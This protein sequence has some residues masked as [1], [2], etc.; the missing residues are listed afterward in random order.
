R[1]GKRTVWDLLSPHLWWLER[2]VQAETVFGCTLYV[3]TRE[4]GGRYIYY[5]GIWEPNLTRWI[6][7]RLSPDDTFI[8]VGANI[9]Y[10]SLLAAKLGSQVVAIEAAPRTFA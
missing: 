5:F 4:T 9:G 8:D 3:D 7:E 2:F 10:Y 1:L 6:Q